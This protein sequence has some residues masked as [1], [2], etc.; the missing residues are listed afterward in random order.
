[1]IVA[2]TFVGF[3]I[4][5]SLRVCLN[6]LWILGSD[7]C[8]LQDQESL[9]FW[10]VQNDA[11]VM[12]MFCPGELCELHHGLTVG[13]KKC[14]R[15]YSEEELP[16]EFKLYLPVQ[17]KG[18]HQV[19]RRSTT[20]LVIMKLPPRV[21]AR[22]EHKEGW[23]HRQ[24]SSLCP[25]HHQQWSKLSLQS[26]IVCL[27]SSPASFCIK[28]SYDCGHWRIL[29]FPIK[30]SIPIPFVTWCGASNGADIV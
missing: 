29:M 12:L 17:Q 18:G 4:G 11:S 26:Y 5:A 24:C 7:P 1:M 27:S 22:E 21:E 6:R 8:Q 15:L 20:G 16:A 25:L 28:T 13:N 9:L 14:T 10:Q 23:L 2:H 30:G 19:S 3:E